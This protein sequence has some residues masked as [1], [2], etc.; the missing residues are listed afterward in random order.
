MP[1]P[2][3]RKPKPKP[4]QKEAKQP[5]PHFAPSAFLS[6]SEP[7]V[8]QLCDELATLAA[9]RF[10]DLTGTTWSTVG[11][12]LAEQLRALGHDL[13][14]FDESPELQEWQATW[15]HPRGTFSLLLSFRA[16]HD[17]E[18]T[19]RTDDWTYTAQG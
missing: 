16:P 6:G 12:S 18:V 15:H 8:K 2:P 1:R 4:K 19:W 9:E 3:Q 5:P 11:N 14:N 17:V 13:S 10:S 7:A